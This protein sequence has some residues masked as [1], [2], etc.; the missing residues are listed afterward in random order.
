MFGIVSGDIEERKIGSRVVVI[1]EPGLIEKAVYELDSTELT[2]RFY[3]DF[4]GVSYPW[5]EYKQVIIPSYTV[6]TGMENLMLTF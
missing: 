6:Y 5:G 4:T 1:A 2:L 3:E